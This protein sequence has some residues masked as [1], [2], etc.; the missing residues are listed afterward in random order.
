MTVSNSETATGAAP[1]PAHNPYATRSARWYA[2]GLLT[3][4]GIYD[5]L[6]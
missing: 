2:L 5:D 3:E 4:K 6:L 1:G